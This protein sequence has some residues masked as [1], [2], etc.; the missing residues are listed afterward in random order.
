MTLGGIPLFATNRPAPAAAWDPSQLALTGFWR[1][2]VNPTWLGSASAGTS[3]ANDL[4]DPG[5]EP[6]QGT[7]L[8]GWGVADFNGSNDWLLADDTCD[9][10]FNASSL[11]GWV[12]QSSHRC[13][14]RREIRR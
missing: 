11:S 8:N 7:A 3:A 1:D 13:L 9:T 6:A 14:R 4:T 2:F 10:Y 12:L 5:N